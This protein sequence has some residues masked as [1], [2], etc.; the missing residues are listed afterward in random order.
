ME[1]VYDTL[2]LTARTPG[3]GLLDVSIG[4]VDEAISVRPLLAPDPVGEDH[5]APVICVK[6]GDLAI[7]SLGLIQDYS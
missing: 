6:A 4:E 3:I 7:V 5:L 2:L 1:E